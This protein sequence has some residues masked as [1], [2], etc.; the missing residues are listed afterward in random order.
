M[1]KKREMGKNSID[2]NVDCDKVCCC[3]CKYVVKCDYVDESRSSV[4]QFHDSLCDQMTIIRHRRWSENLAEYSTLTTTI[5]TR[6]RLKLL[7]IS[8]SIILLL[9][10]QVPFTEQQ[11]IIRSS[12]QNQNLVHWQSSQPHDSFKQHQHQ[13]T[14]LG[15]SMATGSPY[16]F[17]RPLSGSTNSRQLFSHQNNNNRFQFGQQLVPQQQTTTA[18]TTSPNSPEPTTIDESQ[19][20]G[21]TARSLRVDPQATTTSSSDRS[22]GPEENEARASLLRNPIHG[23]QTLASGGA[24]SGGS[25]RTGRNTSASST[26]ANT[27]HFPRFSPEQA[28]GVIIQGAQVIN[29]IAQA[30]T[31]LNYCRTPD[32]QEGECS[33]IRKCIWLVLD[34]QRLKQSVCLRNLIIPAVCCPLSQANNTPI[35]NMIQST[36]E[37]VLFRPKQPKQKKNNINN[38]QNHMIT[39]LRP[40]SSIVNRTIIGSPPPSTVSLINRNQGPNFVNN[41]IN[42]ALNNNEYLMSHPV[43]PS[44]G[45]STTTTTLEPL[46][47]STGSASN[48]FINDNPSHPSSSTPFTLF[49]S[50]SDDDEHQS[51]KPPVNVNVHNHQYNRTLGNKYPWSNETCGESGRTRTGR[52]VGGNDSKLGQWPWMTAMYLNKRGPFIQGAGEFWCGGALINKRFILTA[53]HCLSDQRG[54]KYRTDQ[55]TIKLGGVDL[56]KHLAPSDILKNGELEQARS[57]Q[58][59]DSTGNV[60]QLH[61]NNNYYYR[62]SSSSTSTS[63]SPLSGNRRHR[64]TSSVTFGDSN[65]NNNRYNKLELGLG[66]SAGTS[67]R[68]EDDAEFSWASFITKALGLFTGSSSSSGSSSNGQSSSSDGPLKALNNNNANDETLTKKQQLAAHAKKVYFR[69]YKVANI[70]QHPKFQRHGFYNDIGL[71]ELKS[72]IEYD[73][74]ISP[75]CLPNEHDLKRDM[76]GYMATV[77]GWGT[78]SYGGQGSKLL[79]QVSMPIWNNKD[80]DERY[81]QHIGK[82]FLCAGFLTGGK[83]ACQGDSGGPLMVGDRGGRWTL[84]GVVSFGK[85]CAQAG[86]PG[87]YTRVTEYLD[88]IRENTDPNG[89]SI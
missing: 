60:N 40:L 50:T 52:I 49:Q 54:N 6:K 41:T 72:D 61:H 81:L 62:D 87:V 63:S 51:V 64:R 26:S 89:S 16:Q 21:I 27:W 74:L 82:T 17:I 37:P 44:S 18:L 2:D 57:L 75:V 4:H 65:I 23:L 77:L 53:A 73:D 42:G 20:P 14:A 8:L 67:A 29:R 76:S 80:C 43:A 28:A 48:L 3:C 30:E 47:S 13:N 88:W 39:Q 5:Y 34:K 78:L 56:V 58:N 12:N 11:L 9:S 66:S 46:I 55:V 32:N 83:D 68:A 59:H 70:K 85:T 22:D 25:I 19:Y 69:E 45:S 31:T 36:L 35:A 10:F 86:Y 7:P 79:Q 24:G 33:D 1:M 84:H 15:S 38:H 71:I